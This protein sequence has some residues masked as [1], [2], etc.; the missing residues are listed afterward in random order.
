[1]W[2]GVGPTCGY[3]RV[4]VSG[5]V[6]TLVLYTS[7]YK[8]AKSRHYIYSLSVSVHV[9]VCSGIYRSCPGTKGCDRGN[10]ATNLN[11]N[12]NTDT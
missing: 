3:Y 8:V 6:Q 11:T 9:Q 1:M 2:S 10:T 4:V 5:C 12:M 7:M